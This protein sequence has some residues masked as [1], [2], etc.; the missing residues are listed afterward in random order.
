MFIVS[1]VQQKQDLGIAF[2]VSVAALAFVGEI[3]VEFSGLAVF[4]RNYKD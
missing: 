2:P 3:F 1:P 4:L